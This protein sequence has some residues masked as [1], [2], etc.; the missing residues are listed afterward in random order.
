MNKTNT[1]NILLLRDAAHRAASVGHY[2]EAQGIYQRIL[3]VLENAYGRDSR[4]YNECLTEAAVTLT[5]GWLK[6]AA[7]G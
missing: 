5:P 4:E 1:R 7:N 3:K 2:K 6:E